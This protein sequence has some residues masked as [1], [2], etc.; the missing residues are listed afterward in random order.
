MN[1]SSFVPRETQ[2]S[3]DAY[4]EDHIPPGDF[5]AAVL[6]NDLAQAVGRAD[7]N[8]APCLAA[9]VSYVWNRAPPECWGSREKV[10]EWLKRRRIKDGNEST[11]GP[12]P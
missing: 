7:D 4:I 5:L 3:I 1:Y 8:N 11:Q 9:I 12:V 6:S 10:K 2:A